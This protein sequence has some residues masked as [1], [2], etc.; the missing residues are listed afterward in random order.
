VFYSIKVDPTN[1]EVY[2]SNA[3]N[4]VMNGDVERYSASGEFISKFEAGIIP[5]YMLFNY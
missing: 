2:I 5:S 1:D 4:Y 3:K